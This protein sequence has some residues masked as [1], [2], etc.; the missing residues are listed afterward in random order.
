MPR[1]LRPD[2]G[3]LSLHTWSRLLDIPL[4]SLK[5]ARLHGQ[6]PTGSLPEGLGVAAARA[7]RTRGAS[8]EAAGNLMGYVSGLSVE[9]L[10]RTFSSGRTHVLLVGQMVLPRLLKPADVL[11]NPEVVNNL[12]AAWA[13]GL[14]P[15]LLDIQA[16]WLRILEEVRKLDGAAK[17]TCPQV[18]QTQ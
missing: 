8:L 2:D 13:A 16:I 3:R 18:K 14:T 4:G 1:R 7:A 11:N 5:F 12:P 9:A 10:E 6:I 15:V 17:E